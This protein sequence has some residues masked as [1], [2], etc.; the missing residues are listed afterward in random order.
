MKLHS[1]KRT[2]IKAIGLSSLFIIL[3]ASCGP[4][5]ATDAPADINDILTAGVG[6]LAASIFETQTALVPPP[7]QTAI[8][9]STATN[10]ALPLP[11]SPVS[12]PT[13]GFVFIP[14][15]GTSIVSPT[16]TGT[17]FTPTVNPLSLAT[18]CN[19]LQL[20][21]DVTIPAGTILKPEEP[22]TKTW[23]VGNNGTC[24]WAL[25]YRLVFI[26]G[27]QM[28]GEPSGLGKVIEP[29]KWTQI[30][31]ALAAPKQPGTYTASWRLGTQTGTAF[32]STLTVSIVVAAPTNTPQPT[33]TSTPVTPSVTPSNTSIPTETSTPSETPPSP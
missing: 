18:G 23:K 9:T 5:A 7:S 33:L 14:V 1:L 16:P 4:G 21:S 32:G 26:G 12:S 30:S 11:T 27:N 2:K 17:R 31:I 28:G 3:M 22:F 20:I 13:Q 10:T 15:V 6:T 24:N 25:Q 19:N 29:N 8:T